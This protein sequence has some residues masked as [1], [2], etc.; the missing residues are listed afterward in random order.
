[1]KL[2]YIALAVLINISIILIDYSLYPGQLLSARSSGLTAEQRQQLESL[3]IKT[4]L[5]QYVPGGFAI[6][7]VKLEDAA[8]GTSRDQ[9]TGYTVLYEKDNTCFLIEAINKGIGDTLDLE[10][11]QPIASKLFGG[12]Y[13]LNYGAPKDAEVK[14]EFPDPD[15]YSD[16]MKYENAY[17][18][19][20]GSLL[21]REQY[22]Y[23]N[24]RQDISPDE[25]L[26]IIQSLAPINNQNKLI[27]THRN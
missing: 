4:I 7:D 19:L 8:E 23:A 17:Y 9:V 6:I 10:S 26:K 20:S 16:W 11:M 2:K 14:K 13:F 21:A 22:D 15:L 12:G 1:M 27:K 18:R 3:S 24:C 5:P 25:A